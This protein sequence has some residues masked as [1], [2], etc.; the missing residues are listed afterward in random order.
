MHNPTLQFKIKEIVDLPQVNGVNISFTNSS[1]FMCLGVLVTAVFF[2]VALHKKQKYP[3]KLQSVAEMVYEL[4]R[5]MMAEMV[6]PSE[7]KFVPFIMTIFLF[8]AMGNL[9]GLLPYSFTY[10][11][12]F[13]AVGSMS[14]L[15][16]LI[17]VVAGLKRRGL[18]WF[19]NFFPKGTPIALAPILVPIEVISFC[20]KPL[21]LT[22][23]L[24]VNMMVGHIMIK[25]IAG[26]IYDLGFIGG[27]IPL[28]FIICLTIFEMAIA[29]LQAYVYTILTCVYL[30]DALHAH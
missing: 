24:S 9:L 25:V 12:H 29:F 21:S 4:I 11:S 17:T 20:S 16:I 15:S 1:L 7:M 6:G 3:T 19:T 30:S 23:R 27:W 28:L 2:Y 14:V 18:N 8:V 22:I 13:A 5:G 10:T 26:F